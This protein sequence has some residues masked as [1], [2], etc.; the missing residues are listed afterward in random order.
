MASKAVEEAMDEEVKLELTPMIDISFLIIIFFMCLPFKTLEGKL[1][2]FLPKD[3]GIESLP[4]DPPQNFPIKIHIVGRKETPRTWGPE[5][6]Q[7]QVMMPTEVKYKLGSGNVVTEDLDT[8]YKFIVDAKKT[9][10]DT[11][12]EPVG[13][14]K[15]NHK[16][17]H[18]F[19]VAVLNKFAQAELEKV[20][21][22][23]T[24]VPKGDKRRTA[25]LPYPKTRY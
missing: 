16:V 15:A 14:I 10:A 9:A 2:A 6:N 5:E 21:F 24:Q 17:P 25:V 7:T 20:D 12:Q 19:I 11:A 22:F 23:G 1:A 4:Q 13:E 3:K 8:V 18:K